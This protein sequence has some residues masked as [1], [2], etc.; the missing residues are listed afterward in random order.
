MN[1]KKVL[2][3]LT[4]IAP[5]LLVSACQT[6]DLKFTRTGSAIYTIPAKSGHKTGLLSNYMVNPDCSSGKTPDFKVVTAP[7]NGTIDLWRGSVSPSFRQ[8][9]PQQK[10]NA[11][12]VAAVGAFYTSR[13]GFAGTDNVVISSKAPGSD[14][15]SYITVHIS[16]TK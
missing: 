15:Y 10:C 3:G 5:G 14:V 2:C 1:L 7:T 4:L 11:H 16:V 12:K 9:H 8:G 6:D 13:S